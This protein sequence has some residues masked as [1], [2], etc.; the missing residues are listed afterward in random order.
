MSSFIMLTTRP[1]LEKT[2]DLTLQE[3]K[4]P[5]RLPKKERYEFSEP[6]TENNIVFVQPGTTAGSLTTNSSTPAQS[7]AHE[8][9][10]PSSA[11]AHPI[12]DLS[13][14]N[15]PIKASSFS[16]YQIFHSLITMLQCSGKRPLGAKRDFEIWSFK[17]FFLWTPKAPLR[18]ASRV[19]DLNIAPF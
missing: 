11:P 7:S 19:S 4:R 18:V 9:L 14:S 13:T 12:T 2:L 1:L 17:A 5:L 10:D 6:D 8:N 15:P 16:D 3:R